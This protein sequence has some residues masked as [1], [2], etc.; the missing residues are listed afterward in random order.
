MWGVEIG[1]Y[2]YCVMANYL[3]R[4]YMNLFPVDEFQFQKIV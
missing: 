4:R 2:G 1:N 3:Y